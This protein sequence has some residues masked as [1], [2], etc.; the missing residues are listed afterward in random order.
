MNIRIFCM[1]G[2][3]GLTACSLL[4]P[5][6]VPEMNTYTLAI[7]KIHSQPANLKKETL[8]VSTPTASAGYDS[9]KMIFTNKP[10]ELG[11]FARSQWAA[12]PAEM[13]KPLLI[14]KLRDTGRFHAVLSS[15]FSTNR[16]WLLRTHLI[17]LQQ[18]F[19]VNP[20]R[21]KV[22]VQADLVNSTTH[23]VISSQT[24]SQTVAAPENTPYGGVVAANR[25]VERLLAQV[26]D[27]SVYSLMDRN[28]AKV[29]YHSFRK[30]KRKAQ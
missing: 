13:L 6:D 8:L 5:Q 15:T 9:N 29:K 20:S 16:D 21:V 4:G 22:A 26:V 3:L 1:L 14:Q 28:Q 19:T 12:P 18:D 10:Y 17:E 25:A 11:H 24:F 27:F 30:A 7:R 23:Q 2:L